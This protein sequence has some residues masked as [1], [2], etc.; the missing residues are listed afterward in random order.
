M[1]LQTT[2]CERRLAGITL[3]TGRYTS[4]QCK[5]LQPSQRRPCSLR[6]ASSHFGLRPVYRIDSLCR[7]TMPSC[8]E[9]PRAAS[10]AMNACTAASQLAPALGD[11]RCVPDCRHASA[12]CKRHAVSAQDSSGPRAMCRVLDARLRPMRKCCAGACRAGIA[13][14]RAPS[15]QHLTAALCHPLLLVPMVPS[16]SCGTPWFPGPPPCTP[17][18]KGHF[19]RL[20]YKSTPGISS[21]SAM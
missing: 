9:Q 20:V 16:V 1:K 7:V 8:G 5:T 2:R 18:P 15:G 11:C 10:A 4:R 3:L 6:T 19:T 12:S 13:A 14:T 21:N 17:A